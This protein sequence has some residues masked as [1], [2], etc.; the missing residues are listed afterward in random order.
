[1]KDLFCFFLQQQSW[2]HIRRS[3]RGERKHAQI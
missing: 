3:R 2:C 1:V